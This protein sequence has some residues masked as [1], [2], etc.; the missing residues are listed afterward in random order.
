MTLHV[1]YFYSPRIVGF[2]LRR[3]QGRFLLEHPVYYLKVKFHLFSKIFNFT[4][5]TNNV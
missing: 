1:A 4:N 3:T 2:F 5:F